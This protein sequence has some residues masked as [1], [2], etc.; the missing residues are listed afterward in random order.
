MGVHTRSSRNCDGSFIA[1]RMAAGNIST[2]QLGDNL[3]Q[4]ISIR[5]CPIDGKLKLKHEES[6]ICNSQKPSPGGISFILTDVDEYHTATGMK[7]FQSI[8]FI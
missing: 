3:R 1:E 7:T 6:E 2:L 4:S 8:F 5:Y